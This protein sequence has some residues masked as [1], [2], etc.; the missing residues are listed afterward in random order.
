MKFNGR[1]IHIGTNV[2]I[3]TNVRI[4]DNTTIY[5]NVVMSDDVTICN[6]C[7]IGEPTHSYYS[8][9]N[10]VNPPTTIGAGSLIRS[11]T[12]V[13]AGTRLGES[14]SSGHRVTIRENCSVG[15]NCRIGSYSDIQNDVILEGY[16]WIHSRVFVAGRTILKRYCFLYP[17][18]IVM[19]DP[20]PPSNETS[21]VQLLEYSQIGAGALIKA[22]IVV[23]RHSVIG[24]GSVVIKDVMDYSLVLGNP[25]SH[26]I[27]ARELKDKITGANLYPWPYRFDRGM[28]WQGVPFDRWMSNHHGDLTLD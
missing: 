8:D 1:N 16:N 10:Y 5:D 22:G 6:D 14:F 20:A 28:P 3:G 4:G 17:G 21:P 13:Y 25:A 26:K 7:V 9:K 19:D 23:G 11:H 12:I 15:S 24:A 18:V 27:D 2:Q